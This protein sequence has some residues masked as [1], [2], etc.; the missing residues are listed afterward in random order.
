MILSA[1]CVT[2]GCERENVVMAAGSLFFERAGGPNGP[3]TCIKCN[4]PMQTVG[5]MCEDIKG[6]ALLKSHQREVSAPLNGK[7][8]GRK[9]TSAHVFKVSGPVLGGQ[10]KTSTKKTGQRK[11]VSGKR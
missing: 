3:F 7:R 9:K 4:K 6:K 2:E 11:M 10:R 1:K 5:E 8:V